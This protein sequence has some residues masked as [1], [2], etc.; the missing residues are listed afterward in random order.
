MAR[1]SQFLYPGVQRVW[2]PRLYL[3]YWRA[4]HVPSLDVPDVEGRPRQAGIKR[5]HGFELVFV[6]WSGSLRRGHHVLP[7]GLHRG[8]AAV[9]RYDPGFV[10]GEQ[11]SVTS[12]D[13]GEVGCPSEVAIVPASSTSRR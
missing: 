6:L 13:V 3:L 4:C 9:V 8:T 7:Y 2:Q 5:R 12:K 1:Y 11:G 10:V